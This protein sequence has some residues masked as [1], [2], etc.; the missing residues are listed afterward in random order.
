MAH[1]AGRKPHAGLE[2]QG[3][4]NSVAIVASARFENDFRLRSFN[5]SALSII[6][7]AEHP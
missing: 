2:A 5:Q 7:A 6:F 3:Q 1:R 4:M